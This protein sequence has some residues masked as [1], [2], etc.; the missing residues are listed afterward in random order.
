MRSTGKQRRILCNDDGWIMGEPSAPL[1]VR[2]LKEKMVDTYEGS[3][4]DALFWCVGNR[5]V[6]HY[7]TQIGEIFGTGHESFESEADRR[8]AENMRRLM[9]TDKGP[10]TALTNLCH[11][12]GIDIFPSLRM[13]SHYEIDPS[14]PSGGRFRREHP[15][16]LI[17]RPGE[18]MPEGTLERGIRGGVD[19]S[20]PEVR[21][22][23]AAVITEL[24][25][26]F[27]VDGVELDF[28]RHPAFFRIEEAYG[29]RYLMTDLLR[30][31][32]RRM[33][34]IGEARG[35][36]QDLAVRVPPTLADSARIGLDVAEW[37]AEGLVD[38]VV[39]GGGFIP[40]E[41]RVEEFVETAR[42]TDCQVYGCIESLR[43][44]IDD[45][46]VRAI[47]SRF[48]SAGVSGIYL[49]NYFGK[50]AEWKRR[51]LGEI[52][53]PAA[54]RR[55][56]KRYQMDVTDRLAPRDQH[57]YA[58]RY[59]VPAVQLPVTLAET[60]SGCG[61]KL[62]LGIADDLESAQAE[63][64]L[65]RCA[66]RLRF[67]GLTA[68]DEFEIRINGELLSSGSCSASYGAW[69]RL[70]WTQFPSRLAEVPHTGG[71][72][73]FDVSCPPLRQ[74]QNEV[75]VRLIRRTVQQS[76]PLVLRDLEVGVTYGRA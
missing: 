24:F 7:E 46:I 68:E 5:E 71:T 20:H 64:A 59:A 39:V 32:R 62:R 49:F 31:V 56:D 74:G 11:E 61:P 48:W 27:D 65:R 69:S 57:D 51:V 26:S 13:N 63:G 15:D 52:A 72:L 8:A 2:D 76:S 25:E 34:E 22:H 12:A 43:P 14:S 37:M 70:E 40:F 55:L 60:M 45:G 19:Y 28:M 9:K 23:M 67:E 75:E 53:N 41:A 33:Q 4:V 1:T 30:C 58:F 29:N 3:P 10:L 16:L 36:R 6:Y 73:E 44:A 50:P 54:M 66:L 35:R 42:D 47:A 21:A 17:G 38:I 18:E